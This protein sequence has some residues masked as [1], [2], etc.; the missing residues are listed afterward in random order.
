MEV[1][2]GKMEV[3]RGKMEV[4]RVTLYAFPEHMQGQRHGWHAHQK[5]VSAHQLA[6]HGTPR[7]GRR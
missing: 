3:V 4:V 7:G 6:H 5:G 1:V 2:R